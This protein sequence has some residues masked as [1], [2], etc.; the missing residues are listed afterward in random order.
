M[1]TETILK[2]NTFLSFKNGS[3]KLYAWDASV[4]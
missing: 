3:G 2:A 4:I 1:E